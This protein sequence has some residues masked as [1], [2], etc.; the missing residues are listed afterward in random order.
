MLNTA[1][2][3]SRARPHTSPIS[4]TVYP[5]SRT[6]QLLELVVQQPNRSTCDARLLKFIWEAFNKWCQQ[7]FDEKLG[8][9]MLGLGEFAL[10]KDGML[11]RRLRSVLGSPPPELRSAR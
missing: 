5:S 2:V 3:H 6:P 10:R 7:Q 8:V 11:A 9:R 1:Q 4:P